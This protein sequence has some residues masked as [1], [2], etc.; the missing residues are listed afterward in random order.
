MKNNELVESGTPEMSKTQAATQRR[1]MYGTHTHA[2]QLLSS[3]SKLKTMN[4]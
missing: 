3:T 4:Q 2:D 1:S